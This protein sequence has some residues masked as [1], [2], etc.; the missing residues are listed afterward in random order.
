[1]RLVDDRPGELALA[2]ADGDLHVIERCRET[3]SDLSL[4][5]DPVAAAAPITLR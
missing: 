5:Y 4:D 3:R 2:V 1:M